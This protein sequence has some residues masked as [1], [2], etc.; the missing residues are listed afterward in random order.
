[1]YYYKKQIVYIDL[2]E[3]GE[4]RKGAGFLKLEETDDKIRWQIQVKGLRE[5]DTGFFD[6]RDESGALVDKLLLKAGA[7]SYDREFDRGGTSRGGRELARICGIRL[8][9]SGGRALEGSWR[10]DGGD[11][12]HTGR[13]RER[14]GKHTEQEIEAGG[15]GGHT[16]QRIEAKGTGEYTEQEI[17]IRGTGEHT[18]KGIAAEKAWEPAGRK[19]VV[20]GS[21]GCRRG[22]KGAEEAGKKG[23]GKEEERKARVRENKS[24]RE[25]CAVTAAELPAEEYADSKWDQL[26]RI[27]PMVHPFGDDREYLSITP[28]DFVI[29]GREHQK[30]VHNSFLLHGYYNYRHVILGRFGKEEDETYYL[31]VPGVFYEREKMAAEMFGFEA[32]EGKTSPVEP[33]SFGYYMTKVQI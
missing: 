7:G 24:I 26:G 31:G 13:S 25:E 3:A 22:W 1:M 18:D 17:E 15:T 12:G 30:L 23:E 14:K 19:N 2:M 4:R 33:G 29:L 16:E 10:L 6:L 8:E 20:Q 9:L 11:E 32:F 5:T 21:R 27:Y 28:R